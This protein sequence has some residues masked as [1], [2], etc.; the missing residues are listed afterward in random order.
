MK[1]PLT[2]GLR[3]DFNTIC[4]GLHIIV[5]L[6]FTPES[7][8]VFMILK[9]YKV[10]KNSYNVRNFLSPLFNVGYYIPFYFYIKIKK[11]LYKS[12]IFLYTCS[13]AEIKALIM[14]KVGKNIGYGNDCMKNIISY[15]FFF[16]TDMTNSSYLNKIYFILRM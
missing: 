9:Y 8:G 12:R 14:F 15:E 4:N 13:K 1:L 10:K 11:L 6:L 2:S 16:N 5:Q 7:K 3:I